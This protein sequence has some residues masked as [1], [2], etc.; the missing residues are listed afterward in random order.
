MT[1]VIDEDVVRALLATQHPQ[2]AGLPIACVESAGTDNA[3]FR[4]GERMAVR[5]PRVDYAAELLRKEAACLAKLESLPLEIPRVLAEGAPS[6]AYPWPWLVVS[7][8]RGDQAEIEAL[9]PAGA[10][11]ALGGF[12]RALQSTETTGGP[13]AGPGNLGRGAPLAV[14][15]AKTR[16]WI[17]A[18]ADAF[19]AWALLALWEQALDASVHAGPGVWVHGDLHAGNLLLR[20]GKLSGVI[21]FGLL[22]IGDPA[23]DLMPV[24]N[25]LPDPERAAFREV[26]DA[27][28]A[29][30]TRGKGWA[31]SVGASQLAHYRHSNSRLADMARRTLTA[32]LADRLD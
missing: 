28:D 12:V 24:W 30:W 13:Q 3:V 23:V 14:R 21:D 25:F 15:D 29:L 20:G 17:G 2:W 11:R 7:W 19:D 8:L 18:I 27:D 4:L 5:M 31:V 9:E 16:E 22:G 10:G 6:E 1:V 32:A 26:L